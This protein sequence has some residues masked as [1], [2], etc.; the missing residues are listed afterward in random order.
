MVVLLWTVKRQS[1]CCTVTA[2]IKLYTPVTCKCL[3]T[4]LT[5]S[6][7]TSP[8]SSHPSRQMLNSSLREPL[9]LHLKN[10]TTKRGKYIRAIAQLF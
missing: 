3:T 5:F 2:V 1:P 4:D 6:K 10:N 8:T 9:T 7:V